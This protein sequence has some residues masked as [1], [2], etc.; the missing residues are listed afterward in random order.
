MS[1]A[2]RVA[3]LI[4]DPTKDVR[5]LEKSVTFVMKNG[6]VYKSPSARVVPITP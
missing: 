6:V 5:A 4:S 2:W 1:G 3:R